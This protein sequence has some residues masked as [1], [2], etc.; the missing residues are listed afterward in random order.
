MRGP[1]DVDTTTHLTERTDDGV[2]L[3]YNLSEPRNHSYVVDGIVVRNCS[4]YF[5]LD[6]SACNL[7][8]L[9][10]LRFLHD[11]GEGVDGFDIDA[12]RVATEVTFTAQ[13][14]L[15]GN[16]DY[17]TEKIGETTRAYRQ[18]GLGYTNLGACSWRSV[19]PTTPT[20][21]AV[22]AQSRRS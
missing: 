18:I 1:Y 14:I 21:A 13:E 16:S 4:E 5:S 7:A 19:C 22:A 11:E 17:P 6:N 10:L 20:K 3:T 15:V 12:F 2:E 9:N 8:S